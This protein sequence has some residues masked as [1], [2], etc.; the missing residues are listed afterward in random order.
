MFYQEE[1]RGRVFLHPSVL[2]EKETAVLRY[3]EQQPCQQEKSQFMR[4]LLEH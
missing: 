1:D 2:L 4:L 3:S